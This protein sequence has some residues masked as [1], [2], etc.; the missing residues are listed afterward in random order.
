MDQTSD[1]PKE[2]NKDVDMQDQ[3]IQ[4]SNINTD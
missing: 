1:K 2:E 3:Q 4:T